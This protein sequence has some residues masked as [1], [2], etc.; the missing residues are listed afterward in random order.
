MDHL[1]PGGLQLGRATAHLLLQMLGITGK[2]V[3]VGLDDQSIANPRDEIA[4]V[5]RL[6]Q[7]VGG[8]RFQRPPLGLRIG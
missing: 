3:V 5:H 2:V 1:Q 7:K 8:P 4:G 6:G